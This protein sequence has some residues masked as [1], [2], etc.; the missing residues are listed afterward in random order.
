MTPDKKRLQIADLE[1]WHS[2]F[3]WR[4]PTPAPIPTTMRANPSN[5]RVNPP[6]I[7]PVAGI[8]TGIG[9]GA[10]VAA[11]DCGS[12]GGFGVA[13]APDGTFVGGACVGGT[14]VGGASVGGTSVGG[15]FVGGI[16]VGGN[17]VAGGGAGV[18]GGSAGVAGGSCAID[19]ANGI[20]ID[21]V[22]RTKTARIDQ[23][24]Y[25]DTFIYLFS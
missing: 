25:V 7:P 2:H 19:V 14:S 16:S 6:P 17:G 15:A 9:V 1:R 4:R 11:G 10:T 20:K 8:T 24:E 5:N 12:D 21:P 22:T 13:V 23:A 18:V 3:C